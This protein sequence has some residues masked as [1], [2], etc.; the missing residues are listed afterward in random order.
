MTVRKVVALTAEVDDRVG[1][2]AEIAQP[3]ADAGINLLAVYGG[4]MGGGKARVCCIPD[5]PARLK[6]L[7]AQGGIAVQEREHLLVEGDDRAGVS[8]E[9]ASKLSGAGVNIQAIH[10]TAGGGKFGICILVAPE[11][12]DKAAAA[13]SA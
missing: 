10:G 6:D 7:A 13:L 9:I 8:A 2:L 4:P 12:I 11:D 5:D 1:A 3:V